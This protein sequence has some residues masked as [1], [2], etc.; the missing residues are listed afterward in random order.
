MPDDSN[1]RKPEI[2]HLSD[3]DDRGIKFENAPILRTTPEVS[4]SP[5]NSLSMQS[6]CGVLRV[7]I[8]PHIFR[9]SLSFVFNL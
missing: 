9:T 3:E 6:F 4:S 2:I 8:D 7:R 1:G 5:K